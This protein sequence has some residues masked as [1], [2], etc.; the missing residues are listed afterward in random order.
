MIE[1]SS[2]VPHSFEHIESAQVFPPGAV[3]EIAYKQMLK[4]YEALSGITAHHITYQ[5]DGLTITGIAVLP[6]N[7]TEG[8]H[9]V[10]LYNR[11][12]SGEYGKL[13]VWSVL[14][15]LAPFAK[16]GYL[17]FASNYRGNG[18]S[19][20]NDEFGG[21]DVHDVLALLRAAQQHHGFDGKNRFM[22]GHSRGGM[23]TS[24]ALKQGAVLNAAITIAGVS[25]L[26][27]DLGQEPRMESLYQRRIPDYK[28]QGRKVLEARSSQYW[29]EAISAP[30]LLL[31][32]TKDEVVP[33]KQ[34]EQLASALNDMNKP[35]TLRLFDGGNH[36][37]TRHWDEVIPQCTQ[38]FEEHRL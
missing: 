17:A 32:G 23:M 38:W 31:H 29:P 7:T 8:G 25:D 34:S 20:G 30:L 33:H 27:T 10:Y 4:R 24:L 3:P 26:I 12:G 18:G 21:A 15:S 28:Q 5:S 6:E 19:E 14:Q 16:A 13:T 35:H 37:L 9:P 11:G 36:A 2:F 1:Y 22:M